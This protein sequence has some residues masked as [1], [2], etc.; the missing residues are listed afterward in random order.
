MPGTIQESVISS[1]A[2]TAYS[3]HL[4]GR[5]NCWGMAGRRQRAVHPVPQLSVLRKY[6]PIM[7][8]GS[9]L[10]RSPLATDSLP[11]LSSS[12]SSCSVGGNAGYRR[13]TPWVGSW[14]SASATSR[15][16][17]SSVSF[18]LLP[19]AFATF[20]ESHSIYIPAL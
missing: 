17:I 8:S 20:S 14:H 16:S 1:V 15:S 9:G 10:R 13:M 19:P 5:A 2:Q 6:L 18:S 12:S 11:L 3:W 7:V 4:D